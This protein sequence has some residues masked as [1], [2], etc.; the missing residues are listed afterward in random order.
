[1]YLINYNIVENRLTVSHGTGTLTD[2]RIDNSQ[3]FRYKRYNFEV[4]IE[5]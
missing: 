1:M 5:Y 3:K 2:N 4:F